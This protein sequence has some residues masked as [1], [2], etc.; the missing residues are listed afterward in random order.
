MT[1]FMLQVAEVL[2]GEPPLDASGTA[3]VPALR[4]SR[5]K[6]IPQAADDQVAL[7]SLAEQLVSEAN[8]VL[9][10]GELIELE[11]QLRAGELGFQ[12]RYGS[13]ASSI[14]TRFGAGAGFSELSG[15]GGAD[16]RRLADFAVST[17]ETLSAGAVE[18]ADPDQ[19]GPLI[20]LLIAPATPAFG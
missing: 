15:V 11:D 13:R 17:S 5:P 12:M 20:L 8:A 3:I 19:L 10:G 2:A 1:T 18:L 6:S 4:P 14:R 7:R 9:H 16:A